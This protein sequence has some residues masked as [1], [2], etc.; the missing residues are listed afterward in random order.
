M[1]MVKTTA[2]GMFIRQPINDEVHLH[3]ACDRTLEA[4]LLFGDA[5]CFDAVTGAELLDSYRFS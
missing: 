1:L 2:K 5:C 4:A 3:W